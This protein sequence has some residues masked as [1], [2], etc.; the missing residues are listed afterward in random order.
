MAFDLNDFLAQGLVF[1]GARSSK[2][3]IQVTIPP[4][5]AGTINGTFPAKLQFT[6]KAASIPPFKVGTVQIPYFGRKIKSGGD[7]V[8][9][10]WDITVML[11]EDYNTRAAFEAW[12]NSINTL[13]SNILLDPDT[14]TSIGLP[15]S[16]ETE[17]YKSNWSI[18]HYAK[19]TDVIRQYNLIGGWPS[20]IGPIE[21]NW[22]ATNQISQFQVIVA[23][24]WLLPVVETGEGGQGD[25]PYAALAQANGTGTTVTSP[26]SG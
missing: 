19:D 12:N 13:E 1:G 16:N 9:D 23:Y 4:A 26:T 7:R 6:C 14:G 25:S 22:E 20:Q 24:D 18:T 5:L 3:D 11:D 15:N 21:L 8:W 17:S 2:F 10:D